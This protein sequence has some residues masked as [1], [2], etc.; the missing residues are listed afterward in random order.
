MA[1]SQR[2]VDDRRNELQPCLHPS[3]KAQW[4]LLKSACQKQT[5]LTVQWAVQCS[6]VVPI[7]PS[8]IARATS[9]F[10]PCSTLFPPPHLPPPLPPRAP[11]SNLE[12]TIW[13]Q[14]SRSC[15]WPIVEP[16]TLFVAFDLAADFVVDSSRLPS[17]GRQKKRPLGKVTNPPRPPPPPR[18]H[19]PRFTLF[20][21]LL[22]GCLIFILDLVV[23]LYPSSPLIN[24]LA[25]YFSLFLFFFFVHSLSTLFSPPPRWITVF[26]NFSNS[27]DPYPSRLA[28]RPPPPDLLYRH[29]FVIRASIQSTEFTISTRACEPIVETDRRRHR[30]ST[31]SRRS[32]S[33]NIYATRPDAGRYRLT[34]TSLS[35]IPILDTLVCVRA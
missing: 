23:S 7:L 20:L 12:D 33:T 10:P 11:P 32:P 35:E 30:L 34:D 13:V 15:G 14:G 8:A 27:T 9:S 29:A 21:A 31:R 17:C 2:D 26:D 18:R 1:L 28:T 25:S 19:R 24:R 6:I 5:L 4:P 22:Y 3:T 16:A